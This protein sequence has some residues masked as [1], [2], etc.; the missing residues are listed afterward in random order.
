MILYPIAFISVLGILAL[1]IL[2]FSM[3]WVLIMRLENTF[4]C[5]AETLCHESGDSAHRYATR[6]SIPTEVPVAHAGY[7]PRATTRGQRPPSSEGVAALSVRSARG[8]NS[9]RAT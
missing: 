8:M 4:D 9:P 2:V 3:V 7:R 5:T 1:L 6:T